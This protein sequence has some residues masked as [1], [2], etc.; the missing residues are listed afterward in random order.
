MIPN[1]TNGEISRNNFVQMRLGELEGQPKST[2][3]E[4]IEQPKIK[5]DTS[6]RL[7][8]ETADILTKYRQHLDL[9]YRKKTT[10]MN[11]YYY[12]RLFLRWIN[13][14]LKDITHE[15]MLNWKGYL[16]HTFNKNEMKVSYDFERFYCFRCDDNK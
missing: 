1:E 6:I 16:I 4:I 7:D 13:K 2:F 3:S 12:V 5:R 11:Y 15:D 14:P 10:I 8:K 9:N